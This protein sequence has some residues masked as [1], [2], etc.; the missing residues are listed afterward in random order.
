M[1]TGIVEEVGEVVRIEGKGI[2]HITIRSTHR[3]LRRIQRGAS[4][5]IDGV[6]MTLVARTWRTFSV[7]AMEE[8]LQKTTFGN[9]NVGSEVNLE[10]SFKVGDEVGGHIVS[11]HVEGVATVSRIRKEGETTVMRFEAPKTLV[12]PLQEKGF[13]ALN[14]ASLTI[15]NFDVATNAFDI[16]FIPATLAHTTFGSLKEGDTVNI[17]T[18]ERA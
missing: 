17:E 6:C 16:F 2:Q 10:R 14:G 3:F 18:W 13:V 7:D 11:G 5:S 15:T 4:I 12:R 8:T 1:F 9:L